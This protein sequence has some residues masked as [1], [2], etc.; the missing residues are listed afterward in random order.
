MSARS[1]W[2]AFIGGKYRVLPLKRL[3]RVVNGA[4]PSSGDEHYWDGD[5]PWATPDDLGKLNSRLLNATRRTITEDGYLSCGTTLMPGGSIV[6]STRA[7][8]G[9]VAI[10][11]MHL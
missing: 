11:G 3:F 2:A 6:L 1:D 5:V 9:H 7:P 8:I 4:T 10:A